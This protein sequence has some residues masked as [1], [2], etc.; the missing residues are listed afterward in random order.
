M[1][2][3]DEDLKRYLRGELI[4]ARPFT[5]ID[6]VARTLSREQDVLRFHALGKRFLW[7]TPVPFLIHLL[8]FLLIRNGWPHVTALWLTA[9]MIVPVATVMLWSGISQHLFRSVSSM[10]DFWSLRIGHWAGVLLLP[11]VCY[12]SAT[13]D[14]PWEPLATYPLWALISGVATF[15]MGGSFWGR[16]YLIGILLFVAAFVMTIH[17]EWAVLEFGVFVSTIFS[18]IAWHLY[19]IST[20][21]RA[22]TT[23]PTHQKMTA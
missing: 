6:R 5:L 18:I 16:L 10:R 2:C 4:H 22:E 9:S 1:E 21:R 23:A 7:L 13:T 12:L 15:S 11:F 8:A 17:L 14:R 20:E 19:R 3:S